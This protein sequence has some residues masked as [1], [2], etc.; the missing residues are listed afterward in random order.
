MQ[1]TVGRHRSFGEES[2]FGS[3]NYL[4]KECA[5]VKE[6]SI[7]LVLSIEAIG[8]IEKTLTDRGD[9]LRFVSFLKYSHLTKQVWR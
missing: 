2:F 3:N 5:I 6:A 7:A 8:V 9:W 4:K 1:Y